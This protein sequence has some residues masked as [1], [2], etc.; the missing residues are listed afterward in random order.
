[1]ACL[2]IAAGN[3]FTKVGKIGVKGAFIQT[4]MEGPPLY[5]RCDKDLTRLIVEHL[6][7]IKKYVTPDGKLYCCLLKALYGCVQASKLWFNKLTRFLR[8][9]GYISS[10]TKIFL[11]LIYA[12]DILVLADE[13]E[14]ER[15][16][17]AFV[18]E[19]KWI[20]IDY[21]SIHSYLGMQIVFQDGYPI[22]DMTHFVDK[23]LLNC[24]DTEIVEF[25][26][27]ATKNLFNI[28][29]KAECLSEKDRTQFHRN[30][31]KLLYLTKRARPD[32]LTP[33]DFVYTG[34]EI[35]GTG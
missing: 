12:D 3:G 8:S 15:L 9:Q 27:P 26:C 18:N 30:M 21:G 13:G 5:I 14:M 28:D 33:V 31:A 35:D 19:Y 23:L 6:P 22:I 10:S 32:I 11:L 7:G 1:M 34:H 29:E 2:T 17:K 16:R 24:G 20:T 4:E 25:N